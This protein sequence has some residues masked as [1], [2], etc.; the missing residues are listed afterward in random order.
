MTSKL[1][2]LF[3][4]IMKGI[5]DKL[6]IVEVECFLLIF[7]VDVAVVFSSLTSIYTN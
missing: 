1:L 4:E 3:I 5:K 2:L 6:L 7:F